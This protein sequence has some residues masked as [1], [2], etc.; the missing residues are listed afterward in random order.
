M[1]IFF[2]VCLY[3]F[4][5]QPPEGGCHHTEVVSISNTCFNSQPPEGGCKNR[6]N[7]FTGEYSF[8]SQP[9]E[10]GCFFYR[11]TMHLG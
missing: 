10:G 4:N 9:P 2:M 11:D 5:S 8:N 1:L 7:P 6:Y 3:S